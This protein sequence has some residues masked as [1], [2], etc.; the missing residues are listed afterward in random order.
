MACSQAELEAGTIGSCGRPQDITQRGHYRLG[1]V[2][3][4]H[5]EK[6]GNQDIVRRASIT[7][8]KTDEQGRVTTEVILRDLSKIAPVQGGI[9]S[10]SDTN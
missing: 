2:H 10:D 3:E 9:L 1:R 8:A 4:V 6:V 7:V 5:P